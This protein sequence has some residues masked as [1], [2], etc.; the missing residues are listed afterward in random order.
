MQNPAGWSSV[1]VLCSEGLRHERLQG[2][3]LPGGNR[4]P[5]GTLVVPLRGQ[6]PRPRSDDDRARR[7][8]RPL[9]DLS[10]GAAIRSGI[11]EAAAL[12]VAPAAVG[13]PANRR[14]LRPD[15]TYSY[16]RFATEPGQVPPSGRA[17]PPH[18]GGV[19]QGRPQPDRIRGGAGIA[20]GLLRHCSRAPDLLHGANRSGP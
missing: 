20:F 7:R 3:S 13:E 14:D 9:H 12:A 2:T 8:D 4:A 19:Q 16:A 15:L 6:L 18:R 11:G 10:L 5:G 1:R 17:D